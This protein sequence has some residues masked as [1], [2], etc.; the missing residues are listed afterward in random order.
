MRQFLQDLEA[1]SIY[2]ALAFILFGAFFLL[3]V[4]LVY[5]QENRK[6]QALKQLPFLDADSPQV[7]PDS[8]PS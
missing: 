1:L 7:H 4:F 2:P 8:D 6:I 3:V 5:T